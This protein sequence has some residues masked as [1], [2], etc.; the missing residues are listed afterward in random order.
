M[1]ASVAIGDGTI[2]WNWEFDFS[3]KVLTRPVAYTGGRRAEFNIC[4]FSDADDDVGYNDPSIGVS[5]GET[6]FSGSSTLSRS[7]IAAHGEGQFLNFGCT[8]SIN[9][10]N[11]ALQHMSVAPKIGRMV[12]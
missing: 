11:L 5:S 1:L 9:G 7:L 8:S 6:E 3:G 12:T 2:V 4:E 10:F